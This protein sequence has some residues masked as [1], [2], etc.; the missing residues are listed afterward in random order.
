MYQDGDDDDDNDDDLLNA[1][2][3]DED[4]ADKAAGIGKDG[5][6]SRTSR[7]RQQSSGLCTSNTHR[8]SSRRGTSGPPAN[9]GR[10][11]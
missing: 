8:Y 11:I 9:L 4:A 5:Q 3:E 7:A 2:V 1:E 10:R 6:D